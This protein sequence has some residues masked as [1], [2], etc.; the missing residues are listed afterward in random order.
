M[1]SM[2]LEVAWQC[3]SDSGLDSYQKTAGRV[4]HKVSGLGE[5][6][7]YLKNNV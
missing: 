7:L 1:S 5:F 6:F 3:T 4:T 2:A